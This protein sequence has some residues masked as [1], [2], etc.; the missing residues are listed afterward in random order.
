MLTGYENVL[1]G[2]SNKLHR[3]LSENRHVFVNGI[4]R[5]VF[6]CT[7]VEC[8]Q[9]IQQDYARV[10]WMETDGEHKRLNQPIMTMKLKK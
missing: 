10:S 5:D 4:A 3:F 1:V 9:D 7:V 2:C 6:I 8:N